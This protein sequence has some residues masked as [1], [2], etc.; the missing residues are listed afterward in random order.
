MIFTIPEPC[1]ITLTND[2]GV[3]YSPNYPFYYAQ[4]KSCWWYINPGSNH[5]E[6][7]FMVLDL[8]PKDK[9]GGK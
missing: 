8:A 2:T 3:V 1:V 5:V 6:L 4:Y 9:S 7:D